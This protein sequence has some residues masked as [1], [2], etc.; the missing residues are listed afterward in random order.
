MTYMSCSSIY[1]RIAY[2]GYELSVCSSDRQLICH[3]APPAPLQNRQMNKSYKSYGIWEG[4]KEDLGGGWGLEEAWGQGSKE[5]LGLGRKL[6]GSGEGFGL[7]RG[8]GL[9]NGMG[10]QRRVKCLGGLGVSEGS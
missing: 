9:R 10:S 2:E 1:L 7:R 8:W 4:V 6:K 3:R 5:G